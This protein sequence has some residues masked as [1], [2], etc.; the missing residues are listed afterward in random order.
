MSCTRCAALEEEVAHLKRKLS[1][2]QEPKFTGELALKMANVD[3]SKYKRRFR[4]DE[5]VVLTIRNVSEECFGDP[6]P[7]APTATNIG[8]SLQ[9]LG[10]ERSALTGGL[11]FVMKLTEY[12]EIKP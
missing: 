5:Y 2:M 8:R 12:K 4:K 11:V 6:E 9:A 10:W 7:N 3:F 1:P